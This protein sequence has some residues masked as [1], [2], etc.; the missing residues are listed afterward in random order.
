MFCLTES[1]CLHA[2]YLQL[3]T[4]N[5]LLMQQTDQLTNEAANHCIVPWKVINLHASL[6]RCHWKGLVNIRLLVNFNSFEYIY[7]A[8]L[9]WDSLSKFQLAKWL[10]P[11]MM[12]IHLIQLLLFLLFLLSAHLQSTQTNKQTWIQFNTCNY[13]FFYHLPHHNYDNP[14]DL[15]KFVCFLLASA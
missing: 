9:N 10:A 13:F 7:I 12:I 8:K 14:S 11:W 5:G 15:S 2:L 6:I 3:T 4:S 1:V